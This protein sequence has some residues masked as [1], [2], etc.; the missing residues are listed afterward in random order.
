MTEPTST[1]EGPEGARPDETQVTMITYNRGLPDRQEPAGLPAG[2]YG[3]PVGGY[4]EPT[5][6]QYPPPRM[7]AGEAPTA[8]WDVAPHQTEPRATSPRRR[9]R[10]AWIAAGA[11]ALF[12]GG[13]FAG[14]AL[15]RGVWS[16]HPST[17]SHVTQVGGSGSS[18]SGGSSS[19][20]S[21]GSGLGGS[22]TL[23]YGG[24][25][26]DGSGSF[27][28]GTPGGSSGSGSS[29]P[30]NVDSIASTVSPALVNINVTNGYQGAQGAATGIVLTSDGLVL[31]NNHVIDG[32]TSI[33]ATDVG[34]GQTY[35]ATVVGYDVSHDIALIK[36]NGA[37]GLT[38]A[39]I[40]DSSSVTVGQQVVAIGNAGGSGGTPSAAGGTVTAL[41]QQITAGEQSTGQSEQ[42]SGL[43]ATDADIQAGDS[44][45]PLV[46]TSGEVI[47]VDTA[48]S[49]GYSYSDGGTQ[50]F[51]VPSDTA[52]AI[53]TQIRNG[54]ASATVHVGETAFLGVE[55]DSSAD[56]GGYGYGGGSGYGYGDGQ[57]G[58]GTTGAAVAG[59]LSGSPA[60]QAGLAGGDVIVSVDG[61]SVDSASTLGT[62]LGSHKP[63]DKV[64]LGWV[65][66]S[67]AQHT[68][69]AQLVAGPAA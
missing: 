68:G 42:L 39:K 28:Y 32:A 11:L 4:G 29:G 15:S 35:S 62:L 6:A 22:G 50:G 24:S 16:S 44:G 36:L 25:G 23:P 60:E 26:S 31:T 40:G 21:G 48:G 34:N 59:V 51:A 69:T 64:Q 63:G 2:G 19:A 65:D 12:V 18:G 53:V 5:G 66:Q 52:M 57:S 43:I 58:L 38:T 13:T 67:G 47:G 49:S 41:D 27:P 37:S 14:V 56:T 20:G 33:S 54:Q 10:R 61:Q 8:V 17:T 7:Y 45:G 55:L 9:R 46:T 3:E 1:G 30:S